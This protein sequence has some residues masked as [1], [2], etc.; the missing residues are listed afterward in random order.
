MLHNAGRPDLRQGHVDYV[1]TVFAFKNTT[2]NHV[3]ILERA[4]RSLK[5]HREVTIPPER[6]RKKR[7]TGKNVESGGQEEAG[8]GGQVEAENGSQE[9]VD[10]EEETGEEEEV[11][12]VDEEVEND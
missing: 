5:R 4:E 6:V 11:E 8:N 9:E 10:D 2:V 3:Q 1:P 12:N 7:R